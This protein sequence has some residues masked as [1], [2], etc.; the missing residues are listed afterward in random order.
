M[1]AGSAG[2]APASGVVPSTSATVSLAGKSLQYASAT[3]TGNWIVI[4]LPATGSIA[5]GGAF[6]V[7]LAGGATGSPLPTPDHTN[8]TNISAAQGKTAFVDGTTPL[9][10]ACPMDPAIIDLVGYG[11]ANCSETATAPTGSN[12]T[13]L[14]RAMNGCADTDDN[15]ADFTTGTPMP[16]NSATP[17]SP[18]S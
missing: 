7:Q 17:P 6:L 9:A 5:P 15:S 3:G 18:C 13:S 1:I 8:G 2:Q 4:A 14:N 10:G 12:T 11:T 16:R